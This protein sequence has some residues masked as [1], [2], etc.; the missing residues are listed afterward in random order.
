ME[1]KEI[2]KLIKSKAEELVKKQREQELYS[3]LFK[4]AQSLPKSLA[5]CQSV[6]E[7][8]VEEIDKADNQNKEHLKEVYNQY[9][10][11]N[12]DLNN[13]YDKIRDLQNEDALKIDKLNW[14]IVDRNNP[15]SFIL[16]IENMFRESER[17][18]TDLNNEVSLVN[19]IKESFQ[20]VFD[21]LER[22]RNVRDIITWV[23]TSA[24]TITMVVRWIIEFS[25]N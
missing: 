22:N 10:K 18:L 9:E 16:Q 20:E 13:L 24:L 25:N 12:K 1:E 8:L 17:K 5:E 23:L 11:L 4:M 2:N 21:G 3:A 19:I 14:N 7:M 15:N 6:M